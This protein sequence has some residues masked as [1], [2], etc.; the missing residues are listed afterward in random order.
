MKNFTIIWRKIQLELSM[1]SFSQNLNSSINMMSQKGFKITY[2]GFLKVKVKVTSTTSIA[3]MFRPG[4]AGLPALSR[5]KFGSKNVI[6][7]PNG[8][9]VTP[10]IS[11]CHGKLMSVFSFL[12]LDILGKV[13][14]RIKN[15]GTQLLKHPRRCIFGQI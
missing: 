9:F 3:I 13:L 8:H 6:F 14:E 10:I 7:G 1:V 4:M 2:Y 5:P 11:S 15:P 12:H